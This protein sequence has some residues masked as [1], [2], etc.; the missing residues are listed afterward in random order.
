ML[1]NVLFIGN[2]HTYYNYMPQMLSALVNAEDRGFRLK[3]DQ[4]T[5]EGAG[6]KWHWENPFSRNEIKKK[7]W[8][9]VVLQDRS[10]GP[11]E[12]PDSFA[13]HAKLLDEQIRKQGAKTIF[14]MTWANQ[15]RPD[16]Q[17]VLA[18]A[19]KR[20]AFERNALLA[21]VG[22]VWEA[23]HLIDPDLALHHRDGRHAN[24]VGSYL[25]ACVF[26]SVLFNI[27]PEGL[28]GTFF[29][30]GK[31]R[32]DLDKEQALFLQKTAWKIVSELEQN[33]V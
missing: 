33:S 25:T 3:V 31:K 27:C 29:I 32:V 4:F 5:G 18:D 21:P 11:L 16:T 23:V 15:M 2:S 12:E 6:L 7:P 9:Y 30:K 1:L 10:G 26:Y 8:D 13:R 24:P 20:V 14:Y 19:Y 28:S 22:L 17:A